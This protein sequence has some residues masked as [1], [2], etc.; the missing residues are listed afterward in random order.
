MVL[1]V[2]S[3]RVRA[4]MWVGFGSRAVI[5]G[6]GGE[7]LRRAESAPPG[8]PSIRA[9]LRTKDRQSLGARNG[10]TARSEP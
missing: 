4:R 5:S 9:G 6:R 7:C 2:I 1:R 3:F 10:L 8:V